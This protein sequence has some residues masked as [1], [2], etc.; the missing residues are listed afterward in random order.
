MK[1]YKVSDRCFAIRGKLAAVRGKWFAESTK[2]VAGRGRGITASAIALV[3][4]IVGLASYNTAQHKLSEAKSPKMVQASQMENIQG[5][6][7]EEALVHSRMH[8][9]INTKIVAID[10]KIWGEIEITTAKCDQLI[11]EITKSKF[12]DKGTLII[13]LTNWKNK[14]FSSAVKEHNYLWDKLGG[15]IG[16]AKANR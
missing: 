10:G 1:H 7:D 16:K 3:I 2:L 12:D 8:K 11:S 5:M 9:M 6:S 14:N 4:V 13:F 15:T